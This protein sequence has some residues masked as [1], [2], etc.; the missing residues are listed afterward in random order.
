M[1]KKNIEFEGISYNIEISYD[2][3]V[4]DLRKDCDNLGIMACSHSRYD[5][6]DTTI[7]SWERETAEENALKNMANLQQKEYSNA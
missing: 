6:G 4:Y 5:L 2:E 3:P 7:E 1:G